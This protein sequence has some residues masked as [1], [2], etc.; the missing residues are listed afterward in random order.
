ME[1]RGRGGRRPGLSLTQTRH[2]PR[3]ALARPSAR[4]GTGRASP[5]GH[6]LSRA[7][8]GQ[9]PGPLLCAP[10]TRDMPSPTSPSPGHPA[11]HLRPPQSPRPPGVID[12]SP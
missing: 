10:R 12:T 9:A 11:P 8:L 5:S 2:R 3:R 7:C 1:V 4:P 6:A